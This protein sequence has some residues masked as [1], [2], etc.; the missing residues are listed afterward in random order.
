M[1]VGMPEKDGIE[2]TIEILNIQNDLKD[3]IE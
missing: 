2:A 3:L 1:D